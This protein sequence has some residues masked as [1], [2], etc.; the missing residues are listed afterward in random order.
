MKSFGERREFHLLVADA[1]D[2]GVG[3][4]GKVYITNST[5]TTHV[6][7]T[8]GCRSLEGFTA[9][10]LQGQQGYKTGRC[11]PSGWPGKQPQLHHKN[12]GSIQR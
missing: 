3:R 8:Q 9:W 1:G 4:G 5:T 2:K 6:L 10:L 12:C 7:P 11:F